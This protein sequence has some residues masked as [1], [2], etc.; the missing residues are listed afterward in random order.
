MKSILF[1]ALGMFFLTLA[2]AQQN[3]SVPLPV[4]LQALGQTASVD[5]LTNTITATG[6]SVVSADKSE[7]LAEVLGMQGARVDALRILVLA[8]AALPVTSSRAFADCPNSANLN[9]NVFLRGALP[10][11]NSTVITKNADGSRL[12]RTEMQAPL[13]GQR[14][15]YRFASSVIRRCQE[16]TARVPIEP[17]RSAFTGL[18][19]DARGKT[20]SPCMSARILNSND[21]VIWNGIIVLIDNLN[22]PGPP[23]EYSRTMEYALTKERIGKS[24]MIL[25]ASDTRGKSHCD[26]V[27]SD[28][29]LEYMRE[30]RMDTVLNEAKLVIV[31]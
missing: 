16:A 7:A 28:T 1:F 13:Y 18:V 29:D 21:S 9:F 15:L 5:W 25:Q 30:N 23:L 26:V 3:P 31:F 20:Y 14:G 8:V 10:V 12:V 19:I 6:A 24:P 27:V 22:L 4:A 2:V 11:E 17:G